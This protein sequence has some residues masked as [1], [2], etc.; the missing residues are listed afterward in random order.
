MLLNTGEHFSCPMR[1]L[2]NMSLESDVLTWL[3]TVNLKALRPK[4]GHI[5][6]V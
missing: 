2:K 5:L 4:L 6:Q 3:T 1:T